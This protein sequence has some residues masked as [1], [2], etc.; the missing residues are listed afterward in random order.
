MRVCPL[1]L[2]TWPKMALKHVYNFFLSAPLLVGKQVCGCAQHTSCQALA[3]RMA[4][5]GS[6][7]R[8]R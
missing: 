6:G 5:Q 8:C 4:L 3:A 2:L 7:W 1:T